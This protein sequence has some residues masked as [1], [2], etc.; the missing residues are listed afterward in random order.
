M[1]K[2]GA[3]ILTRYST[4]KQNETSTADQVDICTQWCAK[5][6][7]PIL[8][9]FSDEAVSGMKDTRPRYCSM[10]EQLHQGIGD[11]VVI[12]D[13]SRMFRKMTSWFAFRD[14]LEAMGVTV[15]SATQPMI[16]K[17]LRDP[18]NFMAEGSMALFNQMWVLQTR[19]RV[20]VTMRHMAKNGQHTGG[21]PP[22]GYIVKDGQLAIYEPEASIV[23]RIFTEYAN[24]HTYRE[25]IA[26][27]NADGLT[28]RS[29]N[30]FGTNSLHD[31]LKNEKY[32]GILV[33]GKAPRKA[34]GTRNSHAA[35]PADV[36]RV[37]NAVPAII[38]TDT[39][40]RV[41]RKMTQN[42]RS[43]SGRP[44]KVRDY[45]LKGKVFCG[46]C[47]AAMVGNTSQY[48][49]HYYACTG[50][51]RRQ[52]C[53]L[54]PIS[55]DILEKSVAN[56]VR[57]V[58]GSTDNIDRLIQ[59]LRKESECVQSQAAAQLRTFS[60]RVTD[61]DR[62]LDQATTAILN[63]LSSTTLINRIHL[64]E[65]EKTGLELDIQQLRRSIDTAT[66]PVEALGELFKVVI[67]TDDTV[68]LLHLV[69]RVEVYHDTIKVWTILDNNYDDP[70]QNRSIFD[71]S[72]LI[73][74]DGIDFGPY[75]S[76]VINSVGSGSP[77]PK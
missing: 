5:N 17:D 2:H 4:D 27:L 59:I 74:V 24:G 31:L 36:I 70:P 20:I 52:N 63:G 29:G 65:N 72:A 19:Q 75:N 43:C 33:Y 41:Q 38:D 56:V 39:W 73:P 13:Q 50:K 55:M 34:D 61:I 57:Q 7:M 77:A 76:D 6:K 51:Q 69:T 49:Y 18:A 58:L 8:G 11:A 60:E 26:G 15:I 40:K 67:S 16:G 32:I 21:K 22:L 68:T 54:L 12:Y 3:F 45:P 64:L 30:P 42:K 10:M 44:P 46:E 62:Q 25:I 71:D 1:C 37:E 23:R 9:I 66:I 48:K 47:G 28:T 35:A 14:E 53:D